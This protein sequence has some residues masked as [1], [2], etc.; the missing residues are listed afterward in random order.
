MIAS[1]FL[2]RD[3][4]TSAE[5]GKRAVWTASTQKAFAKPNQ[6]FSGSGW[7]LNTRRHRAQKRSKAFTSTSKIACAAKLDLSG[8][9]SGKSDSKKFKNKSQQC[10]PAALIRVNFS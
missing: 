3:F 1:G 9:M 6:L 2:T 7:R 5:S 10:A 8:L 4:T